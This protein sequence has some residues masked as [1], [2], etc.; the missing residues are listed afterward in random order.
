[1]CCTTGPRGRIAPARTKRGRRSSGAATVMPARPLVP[2]AR[3]EVVPGAR[4]EIDRPRRGALA[5]HRSDQEIVTPEVLVVELPRPRI[6]RVVQDERPHQGQT[7]GV[8][9]PRQ[10]VRVRQEAVAQLHV[11][12]ADRLDLGAVCPRDVLAPDPAVRAE[13]GAEGA[14]LEPARVELRR[15]RDG[16]E[17]AADVRAP[18]GDAG[19]AGVQAERDLRLQRR[20]VVVDVAG[21]ASRSRSAACPPL[22]TGTGGTRAG[23]GA[24]PPRPPR[25]RGDGAGRRCCGARC[26]FRPRASPS[27]AGPRRRRA[28]RRPHQA[29]RGPGG[30]PTTRRGRPGSRSRCGAGPGGSWR[31][32]RSRARSRWSGGSRAPRRPGAAA[33]P[34]AAPGTRG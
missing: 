18:V 2:L 22:P 31:R 5:R 1:M 26:R 19:Q 9:L 32:R 7:Q 21:P 8:R 27:P 20:E 24:S 14:H 23:R 11:R 6:V 34:R 3:P 4:G 25:R 16:M 28:T 12:A 30:R 10:R 33:T 17:E 13:D 15:L 29:A